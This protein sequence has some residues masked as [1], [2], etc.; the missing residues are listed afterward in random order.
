MTTN[1]RPQLISIS[2]RKTLNKFIGQNFVSKVF[3]LYLKLYTELYS[4]MHPDFYFA[5]SD[6][7]LVKESQLHDL[8]IKNYELMPLWIYQP[9]NGYLW[10][11]IKQADYLQLRTVRNRNLI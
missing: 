9:W 2:D 10:H 8:A 11:L 7:R 5:T 6:K 4:V 1:Y 3:D